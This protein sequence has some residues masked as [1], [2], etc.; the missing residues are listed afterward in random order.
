MIDDYFLRDSKGSITL[1]VNMIA[2]HSNIAKYF[3]QS[4]KTNEENYQIFDF[5][6]QILQ[7]CLNNSIIRRF[8]CSN[9][10][11]ERSDSFKLLNR[12]ENI[13]SRFKD[14]NPQTNKITRII[15]Y[16]VSLYEADLY[17]IAAAAPMYGIYSIV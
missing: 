17:S 6:K 5:D 1:P 10:F 14:Q 3:K 2:K 15:D 7:S 4:P 12:V 16:I 8:L 9:S 11:K 13:F